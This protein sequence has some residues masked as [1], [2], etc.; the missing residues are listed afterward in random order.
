[1][2][3]SP[4]S[5]SQPSTIVI[6]HVLYNDFFRREWAASLRNYKKQISN[7]SMFHF[8]ICD[9]FEYSLLPIQY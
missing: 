9:K 8:V 5:L 1:M 7:H 2:S 4:R 6:G 3:A